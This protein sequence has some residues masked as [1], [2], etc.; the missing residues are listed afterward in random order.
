MCL[1]K[2]DSFLLRNVSS[3][4]VVCSILL[5]RRFAMCFVTMVVCIGVRLV[6][7]GLFC[8][9]VWG[10]ADVCCLSNVEWGLFF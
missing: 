10:C 9:G 6:F 5:F 4:S 7:N 2:Y 1:C 3:V 8:N